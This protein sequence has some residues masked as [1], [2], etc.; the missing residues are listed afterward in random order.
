[1]YQWGSGHIPDDS[2][3]VFITVQ[4]KLGPRII[5]GQQNLNIFQISRMEYINVENYRNVC[6]CFFQV[7]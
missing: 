4:S 5:K 3:K 6:M 7:F 2:I 1:M